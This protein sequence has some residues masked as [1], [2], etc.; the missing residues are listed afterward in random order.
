MKKN[1]F[2][3]ILSILGA[4]FLALMNTSCEDLLSDSIVNNNDKLTLKVSTSELVLDERKPNDNLTFNWTTGTNN[5]TSASISY[6]LQIDKEGNNFATPLE[7]EMGT[8]NFSFSIN[9]ATL[10]FIMLNTFGV[11]PGAV[12]KFEARI[13]AKVANS[14]AT[15]QV[16]TTTFSIT[17]YL[18]VSKELYMVGSAT[19][20]G[21]DVSN[22]IQLTPST[23]SPGK[24]IF[25]GT[26]SS[27]S[28]K[29][30]VSRDGCWCQDFYT[31]SASADNMMV[32]NI[33]GSGRDLQW[34]ITQGGQYKITADLLNLTITIE[35]ITG[36]SFTQ[37][38]MVGDASPSGWTVDSPQAFTQSQDNPSVFTYEANFVEGEFKIL[39]GS[40]G[41]WCGEW[42]RPL[43]NGQALSS[44]AVAQNSGCDV[45]NKWK[46]TAAEVGRYK[47]TLNT[48]TNAIKIQKVNLYIIGDGG[49]NGW[50][51]GSPSAMSFSNGNFV[52]NGPLGDSNATGEFKISKFYGDWCDGDW[53][54]AATANQS[55]SNGNYIITHGCNGPD[56]KWKLQTGDAGLYQISINLDT[57]SMAITH[58]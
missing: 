22:A 3:K 37:I 5:G 8:N 57:Q 6:V 41:N 11:Q 39:A 53:I 29:L 58:Q 35:A 19:A 20:V 51:I 17:P 45:D 12:Q 13:T 32:H 33:G 50:N 2:I 10:N 46:I 26:L 55:L 36:P 44:T 43:T 23:S 48:Q 38:W 30:P 40:L 18:P 28:F 4:L 1:N 31:K 16:A 52:Y 24:F 47:I 7:Y 34:Q 25:L 54:N 14:S 15:A 21:W 42:F 56:N 49:P 9:S 27:G